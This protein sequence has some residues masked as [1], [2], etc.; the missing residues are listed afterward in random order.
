MLIDCNEFEYVC[1]DIREY[2][3]RLLE[4][5][6]VEMRRRATTP[7]AKYLFNTN[8]AFMKFTEKEARFFHY[9]VAKLLSLS[10]RGRP[11]IQ[12]AFAFLSTRIRNP[13]WTK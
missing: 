12:T 11:D 1:I 9:M 2:I 5:V 7:A 10:K 6:S 4:E 13:I 8:E 3:T